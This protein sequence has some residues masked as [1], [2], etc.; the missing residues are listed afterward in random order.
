MKGAAAASGVDRSVLTVCQVIEPHTRMD[1]A[2][3][4]VG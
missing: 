3:M 1:M 2:E 4:T